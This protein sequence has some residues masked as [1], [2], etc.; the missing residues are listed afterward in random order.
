MFNQGFKF[1]FHQENIPE[2]VQTVFEQI[3]GLFYLK[4]C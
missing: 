3:P 4:Q 1:L 2:L